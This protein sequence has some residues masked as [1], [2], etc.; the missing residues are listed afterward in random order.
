[1]KK[2]ISTWILSILVIG[3]FAYTFWDALNFSNRP[4]PVSKEIWRKNSIQNIIKGS[5]VLSQAD[6]TVALAVSTEIYDKLEAK[7]GIDS[8]ANLVEASAKGDTNVSRICQPIIDAC[9][10]K[11]EKELFRANSIG[12]CMQRSIDKGF[13][14][15]AAKNYCS[16]FYEYLEGKYN[17]SYQNPLPDSIIASESL[18][19]KDCYKIATMSLPKKLPR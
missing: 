9:M 4:R 2:K 6:S 11:H 7:F 19:K 10:Q 5:I 16:C 8:L 12:M 18:A 14:K 3:I 15:N 1:M 17:L 13:D